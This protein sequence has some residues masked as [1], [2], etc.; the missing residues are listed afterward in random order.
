MSDFDYLAGIRSTY[1]QTSRLRTH[2]L[3]SGDPSGIPVFFIH[4]NFSASSYFEALMLAMPKEYFCLAV[5]LR[6]Y[7]WTEDKV[8]DATRGARDWADDLSALFE[9][10]GIPCAHLLGWSAGAAAVSQFLLDYPA[11]VNSLTLVAPVSPF[12]FGATGDT[13]GT[14]CYDDYAGS[15]GGIVA[16]EFIQR[17]HSRDTGQDSPFSPRNVIQTSFFHTPQPLQREALLLASSLQQ[18]LGSQRYPGDFLRSAN[19]PFVAPGNWGPLNAISPKYYNVSA[20]VKLPRKPPVLWIRGEQDTIISDQ[21]Q[22]D[23]ALLGSLGLIPDWPGGDVFPP[24]PMVGQTRYL[25]ND[26]K[27]NGGWFKEVVMPDAGHSP[28]IENQ[29]VFREEL[30]DFLR[31]PFSQPNSRAVWTSGITASTCDD[32]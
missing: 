11:R 30:L 4:G 21:S 1:V 16:D 8:I 15:G 9:T 32:S 3:M 23:M 12:G 10:L 14:A 19:W 24:Q 17:I 13:I 5:D 7:G 28:F 20:L 26:Y 29:P 22:S 2:V 18:K 6:G 31:Q 27:R 25:L